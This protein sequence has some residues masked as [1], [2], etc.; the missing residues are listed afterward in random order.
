MTTQ[1]N[2]LAKQVFTVY[3]ERSSLLR[4]EYQEEE[5]QLLEKIGNDLNSDDAKKAQKVGASDILVN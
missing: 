4:V 1:A 3:K 2:E 5:D